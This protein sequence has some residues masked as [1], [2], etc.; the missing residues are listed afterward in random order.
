M[1]NIVSKAKTSI[2]VLSAKESGI[3][4]RV[5]V[6]SDACRCRALGLVNVLNKGMKKMNITKNVI[7]RAFTTFTLNNI[8]NKIT[9]AVLR[10]I[11]PWGND[12]G[13]GDSARMRSFGPL[14][15]MEKLQPSFW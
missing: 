9:V 4:G 10:A 1:K 8:G 12:I 2:A 14:R 6:N 5:S 3:P 15:W 11:N 7:Q 13:P